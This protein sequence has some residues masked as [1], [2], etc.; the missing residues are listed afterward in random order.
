MARRVKLSATV[1]PRL[2]EA[3][4]RFIERHP[5][6]DRSGDVTALPQ[7]HDAWVVL[8]DCWGASNYAKG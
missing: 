7:G 1:D 2:L 5:G 6:L 8:V 3:F 4:D